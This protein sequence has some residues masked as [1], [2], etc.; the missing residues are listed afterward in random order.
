MADAQHNQEQDEGEDAEQNQEEALA[1]LEEAEQETE[2]A[3]RE[4]EERL[5]QEQLARLADNLKAI[6]EQQEKLV[7]D[8]TDYEQKRQEDDS[9][10]PAQ[11]A[12][13]RALAR[14]QNALKQETSDLVSQLEGAPVFA[15]ILKRAADSMTD[16][17]G[18]LQK[19][20]TDDPDPGRRTHGRQTL[21]A[22]YRRPEAR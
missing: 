22:A 14:V 1:N 5:A 8:T 2:Q 4:A 7:V 17:A 20:Q 18:R 10:T 11:R 6:A 12:G 16:A 15:L 21:P 19:L 3:R 13:I 9:L